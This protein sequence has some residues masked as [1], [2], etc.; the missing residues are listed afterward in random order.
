MI[1][2]IENA[3]QLVLLIACTVLAVMYNIRRNPPNGGL[4]VLFFGSYLLGDDATAELGIGQAVKF[5]G[6]EAETLVRKQL[7]PYL[8]KA[9]PPSPAPKP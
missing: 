5:G 3:V 6:K 8:K 9:Q 7:G 2:S 4:L 1:E